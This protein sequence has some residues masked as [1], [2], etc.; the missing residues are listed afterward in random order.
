MAYVYL[1]ATDGCNQVTEF[2]ARIDGG[3]DVLNS[4][5]T[6][7]INSSSDLQGG[8]PIIYIDSSNLTSSSSSSDLNGGT[9]LIEVSSTTVQMSGINPALLAG[10]QP[11]ALVAEFIQLSSS[12]ATFVGSE[13]QSVVTNVS[14]ASADLKSITVLHS[15]SSQLSSSVAA[16][17]IGGLQSS[18]TQL[19]YSE[20]NL[21]TRTRLNSSINEVSSSTPPDVKV[22]KRLN[23]E[24]NEISY[25]VATLDVA[26]VFTREFLSERYISQESPYLEGYASETIKVG[27]LLGRNLLGRFKKHDVP[28]GIT[29][30]IFAVENIYSGGSYMNDYHSGDRVLARYYRSGDTPIVLL[31]DSEQVEVGD[32]MV[33][34]GNGTLEKQTVPTVGQIV[35]YSLDSTIGGIGV[36]IKIEI[37]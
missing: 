12:Q 10:T 4:E 17:A 21:S 30:R 37:A 6:Q 5:T 29:T 32:V 19:S 35:G 34:A 22:V 33:S 25:S 14:N 20:S 24:I 36:K 8:A 31:K 7:L 11:Y 3:K 2:T 23:S 28:Q 13:L 27:M 18:S 26:E 1:Y 15:D 16:L 9:V